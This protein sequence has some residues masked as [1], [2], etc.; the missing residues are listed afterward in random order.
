VPVA[1]AAYR[2]GVSQVWIHHVASIENGPLIRK[3]VTR[4]RVQRAV[5]IYEPSLQ[6]FIQERKE[7][8]DP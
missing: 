7:F 6:A 1:E 3:V 2:A 8:K 5:R 4:G